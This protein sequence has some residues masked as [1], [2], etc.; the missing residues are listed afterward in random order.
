MKLITIIFCFIALANTQ[1]LLNN[2]KTNLSSEDDVLKCFR[3]TDSV[4]NYANELMEK[5]KEKNF[6]GNL[7]KNFN[8][9]II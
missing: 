9:Y 3:S 5:V 4:S 6:K 8:E 1:L 2:I 7:F